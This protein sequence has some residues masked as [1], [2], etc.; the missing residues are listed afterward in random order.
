M[1]TFERGA[2]RIAPKQL[3]CVMFIPPHFAVLNFVLYLPRYKAAEVRIHILH[4]CHI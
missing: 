1:I 2:D 3:E 4:K